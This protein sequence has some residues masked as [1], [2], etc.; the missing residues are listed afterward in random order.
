LQNSINK[1][2]RYE[3]TICILYINFFALFLKSQKESDELTML[4][5]LI[6]IILGYKEIDRFKDD[7]S[8]RYYEVLI[9]VAKLEKESSERQVN[10]WRSVEKANN[11]V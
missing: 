6:T 10:L 11:V 5:D 1:L 2:F 4:V 9:E 7:K 3:F 8:Q